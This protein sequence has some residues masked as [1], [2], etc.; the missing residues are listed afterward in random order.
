ME[1]FRSMVVL[2]VL[3]FFLVTATSSQ[4]HQQVDVELPEAGIDNVGFG[5]AQ[6]RS[7]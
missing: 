5:V 3:I 7:R 6:R 2:L 4:V 1:V